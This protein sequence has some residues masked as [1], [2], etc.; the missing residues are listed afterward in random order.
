MNQS[1]IIGLLWIATL[2]GVGWW[3]NDAGH[4]AER[5][6]WQGRENSQL[7][8]ANSRIK[9]MEEGARKAEQDHALAM[10]AISTDYERK[11][12]DA[13]KQRAADIAAV[14]AG[15]LRLRDPGAPGLYPF[16]GIAAQ[17]GPGACQCNG[18]QGS[19]LS[20]AAGEFLFGLADDAD[21]LARQLTACQA[22][23][24]KDRKTIP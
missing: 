17:A 19:E 8:T 2:A 6:T 9:T 4:V 22:V 1:S 20:A 13:N 16:G 18:T 15:T 11:L 23:V 24:V 7:R 3:Q 10:A 5:T 12:S 21:D 14:R